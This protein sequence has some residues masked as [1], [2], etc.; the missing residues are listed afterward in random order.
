MSALAQ[1]RHAYHQ[2]S[3]GVVKDQ[4]RFADGLIAPIIREMERQTN[5]A[6]D[7]R[8][9][10]WQAACGKAR[11]ER[12]ELAE[13]LVARDVL[14]RQALEA[15]EHVKPMVDCYWGGTSHDEA[16]AAIKGILN[17]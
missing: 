6:F 14:L 1:L 9:D 15:L 11:R 3:L 12:D 17:E 10:T 8:F 2:L 4:K 5:P 13:K 7:V 16:I